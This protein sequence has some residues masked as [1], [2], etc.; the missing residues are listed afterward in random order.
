[1]VVSVHFKLLIYPSPQRLPFG[2]HVAMYKIGHQQGPTVEHK[3]VFFFFFGFCF[4]KDRT[5][6]IQ[7]FPG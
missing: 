6:G 4:F 1:M 5:S 7:K 2:N 3:V